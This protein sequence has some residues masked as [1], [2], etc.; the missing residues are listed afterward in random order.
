MAKYQ[1][2]FSGN[3]RFH[4]IPEEKNGSRQGKGLGLLDDFWPKIHENKLVEFSRL[5]KVG[6][7]FTT[8]FFNLLVFL[9]D[10]PL[11][12]VSA[13]LP[14]IHKPNFECPNHITMDADPPIVRNVPVQTGISLFVAQDLALTH[15]R[16][17]GTKQMTKPLWTPSERANGVCVILN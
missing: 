6:F 1:E 4:Q 17:L 10:V 8:S 7:D 13:Y 16:C 11:G 9:V 2:R 3:H 14:G 15:V 5:T 12:N